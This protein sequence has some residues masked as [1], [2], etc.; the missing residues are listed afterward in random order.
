MTKR[1]KI[2]LLALAVWFLIL[3]SFVFGH[4]TQILNCGGF[5]KADKVGESVIENG[6]LAEAY[7]TDGDGKIDLETL[8]VVMGTDDKGLTHKS[9]PVFYWIDRNGDGKVDYVYI[10]KYGDG[11]CESIVLYSD[12]SKEQRPDTGKGIAQ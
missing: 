5:K 8:S 1:D 11:F 4:E 3:C 12:L 7:D 9:F 10:D 2:M 6:M